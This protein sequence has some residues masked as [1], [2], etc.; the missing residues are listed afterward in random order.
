[1]EFPSKG[2][3]KC[4]FNLLWFEI[5]L[6]ILNKNFN[7]NYGLPFER[8]YGRTKRKNHSYRKE[9]VKNP[10]SIPPTYLQQRDASVVEDFQITA[11]IGQFVSLLYSGKAFGLLPHFFETPPNS[12]QPTSP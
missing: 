5:S 8:A 6:L 9:E 11:A 12:E 10:L 1:M 2:K 4:W 7:K 3:E